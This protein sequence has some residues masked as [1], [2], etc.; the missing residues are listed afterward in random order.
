MDNTYNTKNYAAHG[1][2]EWVIGGQLTFLPG[3]TIEGGEGLFDGGADPMPYQADSTATTVAALKDDFNT[4]LAAL[5]SA[6]LMAAEA[7]DS[8]MDPE[9]PAGGEG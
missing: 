2:A 6:G 8:G 1:G 7:E 4:L 5:R 3:A 9:P